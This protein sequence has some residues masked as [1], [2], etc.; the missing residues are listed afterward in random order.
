MLSNSL[1]K[2]YV[3]CMEGQ[4]PF[5]SV[6]IHGLCAIRDLASTLKF[7]I[8]LLRRSFFKQLG[9]LC[10]DN[11]SWQA[12]KWLSF[13]QDLLLQAFDTPSQVWLW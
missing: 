12:C 9:W 3:P 2:E 5:V 10:D 13:M 8:S 7:F 4:V 6:P 11:L 1:H